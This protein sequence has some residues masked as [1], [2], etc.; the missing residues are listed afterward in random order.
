MNKSV[1]ISF[2]LIFYCSM[3]F[4]QNGINSYK[5]ILVP[6]QF[7]F[8]NS[9]DQHQLNSL[10]KFLFNKAGFSV[11]FTN[12]Q[13][14]EDLIR[15]GCLALKVKV[16]N[17]SSLFKTKMNIDLV[18]C[19]NSKIYSTKEAVSK[20]KVYK[21]AYYE[22]IRKTFVD[23]EELNYSYIT[24]IK[25]TETIIARPIVVPKEMKVAKSEKIIKNE[26]EE[27][28]KVIEKNIV[29]TIEGNFNFDN[30]GLSVI[31]KKDDYYIVVGGDENFEFATI[32]KTLKP[33]IFIIKWI[34]YKQPQLI[35][36]DLAGN[37]QI[38]TKGGTKAIKRVN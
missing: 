18:D 6:K 10:V 1:L 23:L 31:S 12:E 13:Y 25:T 19:R 4:A 36:I 3:L 37:L 16:N 35:E 26:K 7:E 2:I 30:W 14:P 5:Y 22:A 32:Y 27:P 29:K 38:D 33:T 11:L 8:Q 24:D 28:S 20:E 21:K 15:N 17:N 34:A 9:Q